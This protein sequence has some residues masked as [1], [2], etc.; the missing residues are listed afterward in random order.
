MK[1]N[2]ERYLKFGRPDAG[3]VESSAFFVDFGAVVD[4]G[5]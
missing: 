2:S 3:G 5:P 4:L 1:V